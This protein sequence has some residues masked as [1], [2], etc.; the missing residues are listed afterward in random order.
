MFN[1]NNLLYHLIETKLGPRRV[2]NTQA[3]SLGSSELRVESS[4]APT[5]H[6]SAPDTTLAPP[7]IGLRLRYILSSLL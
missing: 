2:R 4:C 6:A 1:Q 5:E 3:S 7:P